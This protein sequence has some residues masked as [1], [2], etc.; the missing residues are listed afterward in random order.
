MSAQSS[1]TGVRVSRN[2]IAALRVWA[3]FQYCACGHTGACP[4]HLCAPDTDTHCLLGM[5]YQAAAAKYFGLNHQ[6]EKN[7]GLVLLVRQGLRTPV[8]IDR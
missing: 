3:H 1:Q 6:S 8:C 4:T 5:Y 7:L 2:L